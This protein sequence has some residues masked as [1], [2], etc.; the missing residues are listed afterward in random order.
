MGCPMTF[1]AAVTQ[2]VHSDLV[3][4]L[5]RRDGQED[6]CFALYWPSKGRD[7]VSAL[8]GYVVL[9][10]AGERA[11]H[12]NASFT[13]DYFLRAAVLAAE[14]GAGLALLHSHPSGMGWQGMSPDDIDA[15]RSHAAQA[16]AITGLPLV[17]LTLGQDRSWSCRQWIRTGRSQYRRVDGDSVRVVGDRMT[18]TFNPTL[19]PAAKPDGRL[20]RTV[21]AWGPEVQIDFTRLRIG[22]VGVGSVGSQVAESLARTGVG[23]IRL[24]DFDSVEYRNLDRLLHATRMDVALARSKVEVLGRALAKSASASPFKVEPLEM[25]VCEEDGFRA[26][27]DC[28]LLFCCVD[29]P[30]S[31]FVLN[32]IAY[33][34]LIPVVDG[35]VYVDAA[36]HPVRLRSADWR[37]YI[38]G[39][40]RKCLECAGQ[41]SPGDVDTDKRGDLDDPHYIEALA[42]D[43][44][45]RRGENVYAFSAACASLEVLQALVL[46]VAPSGIGDIGGQHYHLLPGTVDIDAQGCARDCPFS[47]SI[48][49][50]GEAANTHC[51]GRH[52]R[53][54]VEIEARRARQRQPL[55]RL[56]RWLTMLS[57]AADGWL[58][59]WLIRADRERADR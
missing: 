9:P 52:E 22:I 6:V 46:L 59:K 50:L 54:R 47:E 51:T 55:V 2:E 26:A 56:G 14:R 1:S 43:H 7:R 48:L 28:D 40:G 45:A 37:A 8:V 49:G 19:R 23:E 29:R 21:S 32:V 4:H 41:Y 35:G 18:L 30:W 57:A 27:L 31:R 44:P 24:I 11:V 36:M 42:G 17:G 20:E 25:S 34:H 3:A 39:P 38:A 12:G 33:A 16:L 10:E 13:S 15:E 53:A 58:A 5:E